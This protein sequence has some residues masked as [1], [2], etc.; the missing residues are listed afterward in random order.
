MLNFET[1]YLQR[2]LPRILLERFSFELDPL[3]KH[4]G[5][6]DPQY[7]ASVIKEAIKRN[8]E[9]ES[10]DTVM[11]LYV[12]ALSKPPSTVNQHFNINGHLIS[13]QSS[14]SLVESGTTAKRIWEASLALVNYLMDHPD[15]IRGESILE[16]GSGAG[17]AGLTSKYLGAA[18]VT[19]TDLPDVLESVTK[20]NF[21]RCACSNVSLQSLDWSDSRYFAFS[22]Y[23][24]IVGAD[25][26]YDPQV[27]AFLSQTLNNIYQQ[28]PQARFYL[29]Q[30]IRNE[31]TFTDF[32]KG[33]PFLQATP[34]EPV[35]R[36]FFF[37][38]NF[39]LLHNK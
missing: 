5:L 15:Q 7:L 3:I 33:V 26:I 2:T 18:S 8:S 14:N 19:L 37:E 29:M 4:K 27:A 38:G 13:F 35:D 25:L 17:F 20:P 36:R 22:K 24:V 1:A 9:W 12:E 21:D 6:V 32:M 31:T 16:L 30:C 34:Y 39:Y 23:S 10:N 11:E 28:N